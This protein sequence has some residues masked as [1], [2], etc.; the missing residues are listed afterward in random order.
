MSLAGKLTG[1]LSEELSGSLAG[2]PTLGELITTAKVGTLIR[3]W[4]VPVAS[5]SNI[6]IDGSTNVQQLND[7]VGAGHFTDDSAGTRPSYDATGGPN[8]NPCITLQDTA[9]VLR[10]SSLGHAAGLRLGF[11]FVVAQEGGAGG[12]VAMWCG[13]GADSSTSSPLAIPYQAGSKYRMYAKPD[14]A[15]A[16]D[17]AVTTPALGSSWHRF[18]IEFLSTGLVGRIGSTAIVPAYTGSAAADA[19]GCA[20]M[21]QPAAASRGSFAMLA[22]VSGVVAGT[23]AVVDAYITRECGSGLV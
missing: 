2:V 3:H 17:I 6:V 19:F 5:S 14:G 16:Q 20:R 4:Q 12:G 11:Y 13:T 22:V 15:A 10:A 7:L 9:R 18:A 21:G 8:G 1:S 23:R